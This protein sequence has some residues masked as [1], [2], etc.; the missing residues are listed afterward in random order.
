MAE[1]REPTDRSRRLKLLHGGAEGGAE[2]AA[3]VRAFLA[4]EDGALGQL[5]ARHE[6]LVLA[7]LRRYANGPDDAA[8]LVQ[9][10][11]LRA[12]TAARRS[13]E[14]RHAEEIPFRAWLVR[15][16]VNLG[17]NHQRDLARWRRAPLEAVDDAVQSQPTGTDELERQERTRQLRAA[18]LKLPRRQRA[19]LQLRID[20]ELPFDEIAA[21]LGIT[22]NNAKVH[23]HHATRKLRELV[24][25]RQEETP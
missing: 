2:D 16:A 23:F 14:L 1:T 19:V 22:A 8:D 18:V 15:I 20:A 24:G 25:E 13:F 9:R 4:G 7:L 6:R 3:L 5:F 10:T 17:K 11:F 12:L 21:T